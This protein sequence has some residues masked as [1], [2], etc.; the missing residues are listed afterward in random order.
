MHQTF[1]TIR[2]Y[3]LTNKFQILSVDMLYKRDG[4][5]RFSYLFF[6]ANLGQKTV[7]LNKLQRQ[8]MGT[9]YYKTD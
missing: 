4:F 5:A 2:I 9:F 3:F 6:S 7:T 8:W 1:N